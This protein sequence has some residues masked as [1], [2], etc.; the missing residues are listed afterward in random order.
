MRR[1]SKSPGN[2]GDLAES[3]DQMRPNAFFFFFFYIRFLS[4]GTPSSCH[5]TCPIWSRIRDRHQTGSRGWGSPKLQFSVCSFKQSGK[6]INYIVFLN[7][8]H[9]RTLGKQSSFPDMHFS[10]H[11]RLCRKEYQA[12]N[13]GYGSAGRVFAENS[14]TPEFSPQHYTKLARWHKPIIP[15]RRERG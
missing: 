14:R 5:R 15:A 13:Q 2:T 6:L 8:E 4:P 1:Q 9:S 3:I 12:E 11:G 7:C 10:K